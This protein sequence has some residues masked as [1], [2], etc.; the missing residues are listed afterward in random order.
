M[1]TLTHLKS[2]AAAVTKYLKSGLSDDATEAL[3]AY[4]GANSEATFWVGK[5]AD[6]LQLTGNPVDGETL[7]AMLDGTLPDGTVIQTRSDRRLGEELTISCP[8]SLSIAALALG[9]TEL[10]DD[11]N[12][13]VTKALEFVQER[14][15]YA[16]RGKDGLE[17]EDAPKVAIAVFRHIDARPVSGVVAP[18]L[19]SHCVIPN[20]AKRADGTWGTLKIDMGQRGDLLKLADAIYKAALAER[21]QAR[22]IALRPTQNGFELAS[23]D[24]ETIRAWSPRKRQI[25]AMLAQKGKT[26]SDSTEAERQWANLA[27]R[28]KKQDTHPE[29]YMALWR[30]IAREDGLTVEY[31]T[32]LNKQQPKPEELALNA[33]NHISEREATFRQPA[34]QAQALLLGCAYHS[35]A[36]MERAAHAVVSQYAVELEHDRLCTFHHAAKTEYTLDLARAAIGTAAPLAD[37]DR[38]PA[39]MA[40]QEALQGFQYSADQREAIRSIVTSQDTIQ[41]LVGAAGAGKTTALAGVAKVAQDAGL[42][43]VGLAPSHVAKD[44]LAESL[45]IESETLAKWLQAPQPPKGPRLLI[46]DEAGMVGTQD[47][48]AL[49]ASLGPQDRVLLVGD[50][51]QLSPIAAGQPFAELLE[52]RPETPMLGQIRRQYDAEQRRIATLYSQGRGAEAAQALLGFAQEVAPEALVQS[53]ASAYLATNGTKV[54]L[55]SKN[56]TVQALNAEIAQRLHGNRPADAAVATIRKVP[57]TKAQRERMSSYPVGSVIAKK[58]EVRKITKVEGDTVTTNRG[59]TITRPCER[60]WDLVEAEALDLWA[61]DPVLA[62][63]TLTLTVDGKPVTVRNGTVLTVMGAGPDGGAALA[64][65]DGRIGLTDP[66]HAVPLAYGW[67]RTVHKSQGQ[68]VDHA[69]VVDDGITG[70]SLGYVA[71]SRQKASL[72]ILT[73]DKASLA[74]RLS[75]WAERAPMTPTQ[76]STGRLAQAR[77]EGAAYARQQAAVWQQAAAKRAEAAR[78][79]A[80]AEKQAKIEAERR[81]REAAEAER[82]RQAEAARQQAPKTEA[83]QVE[84][85]QPVY[86]GRRP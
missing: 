38:L 86:W 67:A 16:R 49:F 1:I 55:A 18:D 17:R 22:G 4:Y 57:M 71:S 84:T 72:T 37:Q 48:A 83:V 61:G 32:R 63:D 23:I 85:P 74:D 78:A 75:T 34:L 21:L 36:T 50:P 26:R 52:Q 33:F 79:Q 13:A 51:R 66:R 10:L 35:R 56:A 69:V 27:T 80:E 39:L 43:V 76:S 42:Q 82:Q 64:L 11:H 20:V 8:K 70:A 62:T 60:G 73:A 65:P 3:A 53:A 45:G 9:K 14:L 81:A 7:E 19:H 68:T 5:L 58:G 41:T 77:Q 12:H 15:V 24:D 2:S 29:E 47:M 44:A 40:E 46:L 30:K 54:L 6:D 28:E 31:D 25:D 59:E